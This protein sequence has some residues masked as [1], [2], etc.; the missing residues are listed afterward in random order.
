[1]SRQENL[2]KDDVFKA[3]QELISENLKPTLANLR[4]KVGGSFTTLS[5]ILKQWKES[6][7]NKTQAILEMPEGLNITI[8]RATAE[9]WKTASDIANE[10]IA[11][12]QSE[13]EE[14]TSTAEEEVG[15]YKAE[16]SRL[17]EGLKQ[18]KTQTNS[19][20][21]ENEK[22]KNDLIAEKTNNASI[23][24]ELSSLKTLLEQQ[25]S[26]ADELQSELINLVKQVNQA[27]KINS[28]DED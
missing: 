9:L 3:I 6:Q 14:Q 16:V 24:G 21:V 12:I 11:I 18:E 15:E 20:R 19:L 28:N 25:Q 26:R 8:K 5:P 23:K 10:K 27:Q 7:Q 1:M 17:E 2:T 22:L 13:A 4:D